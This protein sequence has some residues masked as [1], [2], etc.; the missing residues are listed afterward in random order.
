MVLMDENNGNDKEFQE[1]I[2]DDVPNPWASTDYARSLYAMYT[3][4]TVAGFSDG[5]A[6]TIVR[7]FAKAV[8]MKNLGLK[9][10]PGN[11]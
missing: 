11:G 4:L 3:D 1:G 10:G 2:S 7:D 9:G 5:Q 6:F 8:A